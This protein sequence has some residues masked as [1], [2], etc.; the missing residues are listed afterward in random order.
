MAARSLLDNNLV[1]MRLYNHVAV[2]ALGSSPSFAAFS[3]DLNC[4]SLVGYFGLWGGRI[5]RKTRMQNVDAC[6]IINTIKERSVKVW[7]N[8]KP[9]SIT[10]DEIENSFLKLR[11]VHPRR[12]FPEVT[13]FVL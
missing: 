7:A 6:V 9:Y 3:I 2:R 10:R 8:P 1:L 13:L 11:I 5:W 12:P 4:G